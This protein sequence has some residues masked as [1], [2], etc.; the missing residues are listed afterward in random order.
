M[1]TWIWGCMVLVLKAALGTIFWW[2]AL[3]GI[4]LGIA[5]IIAIIKAIVER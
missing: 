1:W 2:I 5:G 3:I 4:G